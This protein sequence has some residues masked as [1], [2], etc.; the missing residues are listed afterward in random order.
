MATLRASSLLII[1]TDVDLDKNKPNE[2]A[3]TVP[4]K[5]VI[6]LL[7]YTGIPSNHITKRLNS[8]V[9]HFYT[10]LLMS[11]LFFKT[12][13]ESNPSTH[14]KTTGHNVI[15]K[16]RFWDC[17]EFYANECMKIICLNRGERYEDM[18]NYR[19]HTQLKQL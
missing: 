9:N 17:N 14:T 18:I 7:P 3:A 5:Y 1:M 13:C 4:Q 10:V 2:P 11:K 12:P 16:A 8:C 19:S 15:Y 6:I